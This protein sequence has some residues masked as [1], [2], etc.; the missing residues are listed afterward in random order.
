ML[1]GTKIE[2]FK[3]KEERDLRVRE[4]KDKGYRPNLTSD[5][6]PVKWE[7]RFYASY[8]SGQRKRK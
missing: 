2:E 7:T 5:P 1:E 6:V 3:T 8:S 4:L